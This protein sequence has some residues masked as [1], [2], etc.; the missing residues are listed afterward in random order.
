MRASLIAA[1][2]LLILALPIQSTAD[3]VHLINGKS[4]ENVVAHVDDDSVTVELPG[5]GE[6]TLSRQRVERVDRGRTPLEIYRERESALRSEPSTTAGDWLELAE[7]ARENGLAHGRRRAALTAARLAPADPAVRAEMELLGYMLDTES[8]E[9][10]GVAEAMRRRGL[11]PWNGRWVAPDERDREIERDLEIAREQARDR[12]LDRL[13]RAIEATTELELAK[14]LAESRRP[15]P[16]PAVA[17]T[18]A[19]PIYV[20]AGFFPPVPAPHPDPHP[21]PAPDPGATPPHPGAP[22]ETNHGVRQRPV[23]V[24]GSLS[25]DPALIPGRLGGF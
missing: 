11:V 24:P 3:E 25:T 7:W 22:A 16:Q 4:F 15:D 8:G 2:L 18:P 1:T 6:L 20:L 17:Y 23:H 5:G 21:D 19:Y 14:S 12:R 10:M 13:T 9:W